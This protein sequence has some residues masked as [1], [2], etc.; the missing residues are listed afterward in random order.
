MLGSPHEIAPE[1]HD[2]WTTQIVHE[3]MGHELQKYVDAGARTGNPYFYFFC[4]GGKESASSNPYCI[5]IK[6]PISA[7]PSLKSRRDTSL[8]RILP[9]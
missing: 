1:H 6:N 9:F 2:P 3:W 4:K 7:M 5:P 8:R